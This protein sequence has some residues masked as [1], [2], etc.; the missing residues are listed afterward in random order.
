MTSTK[1]K[2]TP[3]I[4]HT[5]QKKNNNKKYNITKKLYIQVQRKIA[6]PKYRKTAWQYVYRYNLHLPPNASDVEIFPN[7]K[8]NKNKMHS[9]YFHDSFFLWCFFSWFLFF[10]FCCLLWIWVPY[11]SLCIV[12]CVV[13]IHFYVYT[14]F[15]FS[16]LLFNIP[17]GSRKNWEKKSIKLHSADIW[18]RNKNE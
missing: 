10:V 1:R 11:E 16:V 9:Q 12:L 15:F 17:I 2:L 5:K 14:H 7:N 18:H 13:A 3:I 8:Q 4:Q 6:M